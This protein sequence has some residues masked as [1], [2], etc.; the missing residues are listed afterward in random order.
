MFALRNMCVL[1][2]VINPFQL[3]PAR[4]DFIPCHCPLLRGAT[5]Y[6]YTEEII[7][8]KLKIIF[9]E[10]VPGSFLDYFFWA[11]PSLGCNILIFLWRIT[12]APLSLGRADVTLRPGRQRT[13]LF[14]PQ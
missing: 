2:P 1:N 4:A 13:F 14:Q 11:M 8:T 6:M 3:K 7:L 9:R 10:F 12:P 5:R